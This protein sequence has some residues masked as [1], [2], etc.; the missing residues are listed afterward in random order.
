MINKN[1][2]S[3]NYTVVGK[4]IF[5]GLSGLVLLLF[6]IAHLLGNLTILAGSDAINSYG[7][8][9]HQNKCL[10]YPA[11]VVLLI[12][13]LAHLYYSI[14]LTF[15]NNQAKQTD[16]KYKHNFSNTL[17]SKTMIYSGLII[18]VF[19]VYHLLH[20][21]FGYINPGSYGLLDDKKR[22]DIFTMVVDNFS[23]GYISLIYV[24]SLLCL[25]LH[26]SHAFFSVCQT[27]SIVNTNQ[28]IHIARRVSLVFSIII[29]IGYISIPIAIFME[30][31]STT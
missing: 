1:I 17:A 18:L 10:V 19:L 20:F 14:S 9:L 7:H 28:S 2:E 22:F 29:I 25:G 5:V 24:V 6:I 16:Y 27:L 15:I 31:I 8:F 30:I 4:K 13:L 12:M 26:L 3:S 23:N 21:T 11:R